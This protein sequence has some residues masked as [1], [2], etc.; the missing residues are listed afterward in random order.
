MG[1]GLFT[2]MYLKYKYIVIVVYLA[3]MDELVREDLCSCVPWKC[4]ADC[5]ATIPVDD[6]SIAGVGAVL[7]RCL[8]RWRL[9]GKIKC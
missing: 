8:Q 2:H 4:A 9:Q 7:G 1:L 6:E 5:D 3:W